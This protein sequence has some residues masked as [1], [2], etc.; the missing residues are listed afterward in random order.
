VRL[1]RLELYGFKSF[2]QKT[3]LELG[4]GITAIVGP[5]G[6]GKSNL[7][8]AIR[9]ALGEQSPRQLRGSKMEDVIFGG[10]SSRKALGLA[11]VALYFDNEDGSLPIDFNEVSV[12]RR[13]YRSGESE[14][15]L[16]NSPCRLRDI[17]DLFAGTGVGRETYATIEQG[18]ID[19]LCSGRSEDRRV[20][21][22]EASGILKYKHKKKEALSKLADT[23]QKIVRLNDLLREITG[24]LAPLEIARDKALCYQ[25]CSAELQELE[26]LLALD[27]MAHLQ[28]KYH[29]CLQQEESYQ[30]KMEQL[31][32]VRQTTEE[33]LEQSAA[34]L[35]A[36]QAKLSQVQEEYHG[37]LSQIELLQMEMKMAKERE[38][39]C[40][41]RQSR[42]RQREENFAQSVQQLEGEIREETQFLEQM[43]KEM[44]FLTGREKEQK[45]VLEEEQKALKK[46]EE[47]LDYLKGELIETLNLR[48]KKQYEVKNLQNN[49]QALEKKKARL[50]QEEE[51]FSRRKKELAQEQEQMLQEKEAKK[52]AVKTLEEEVPTLQEGHAADRKSLIAQTDLILQLEK[53]GQSCQSRLNLLL[54][55][56]RSLEGY[57]KGVKAVLQA[58]RKNSSLGQGISGTVAELIKVPEKYEKAIETALG[59]ALQNIVTKTEKKAQE[60][61]EYLK[62]AKSGRATFLPLNVIQGSRQKV[63]PMSGVL[64]LGVD[65]VEFA[66]QYQAVMEYLLGR[67]VIVEDLEKA[68]AVSQKQNYKLRIVTLEGDVITPGGAM[69][70]GS[71]GGKQ[72]GFLGRMREMEQLSQNL[73]EIKKKLVQE[74]DRKKE[75][76]KLL[77]KLEE[78]LQKKQ[79]EL[80][81]HKFALQSLEKDWLAKEKATTKLNQEEELMIWEQKQWEQEEELLKKQE[82]EGWDNCNSLE[83]NKE[84]LEEEIN[85]NQQDLLEKTNLLEKSKEELTQLKV[86][87]A[88]LTQ[89]KANGEL[90]QAKN[91]SRLQELLAEGQLNE[92]ETAKL[93]EQ[94]ENIRQERLQKKA[95]LENLGEEKEKT[96]QAVAQLKEEEEQGKNKV[97]EKEKS[98]KSLE[99]TWTNLEKEWIQLAGE[100]GRLEG[101]LAHQLIELKFTLEFPWETADFLLAAEK[102][103]QFQ[104]EALHWREQISQLGMVNLGALEEYARLK[105]RHDFLEEQAR[106]LQAAKKSL[107]KLLTEL[108]EIMEKRFLETFLCIQEEFKTLFQRLFNGGKAQLSLAEPENTLE[109]GIEIMVQPP[110]KKLQNLT[111]LSGGE[112]GLTA[113]AL[114]FALLKVNPS[115]F[116][117]LDEIDAAFDDANVKRVA[118]LLKE[119]AQEIQFLV[120]THRKGIMEEADALYGVT[121]EEAGVSHL[122]SVKLTERAS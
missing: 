104:Q 15:H 1:K 44:T 79:E 27:I 18:K 111:L 48:A 109:T 82:A 33:E 70:G 2:A 91:K 59:P 28:E 105:K 71:L 113:V 50:L 94:A 32:L 76:E 66:S 99:R 21:F 118:D 119:F 93:L 47:Y 73:E 9:W 46:R 34:F 45:K 40:L 49:R 54:E 103:A 31:Q 78:T 8:D 112:K 69:S 11:E 97:K 115:P 17:Y 75:Q 102:K 63:A 19:L 13:I 61:I 29:S 4:E 37:L 84:R 53:D 92:Q 55:M 5:N 122:V 98:K 14:Y 7:S 90:N 20:V 52:I 72:L 24:Q 57:A 77:A 108:D 81:Q 65:L 39:E 114:L 64:G 16:N 42:L 120:I 96:A 107:E 62:A 25:K 101:D 80:R 88:F 67:I 86:Q 3:K 85:F 106:D 68:L 12:S 116:C 117:L 121:M 89:K 95:K 10:S 26:R 87:L 74:Q 23:A 38:V 30:E 6:S 35:E 51:D 43:T 22:E 60:L 100:K 110:G 41:E 58:A 83:K 56:E 36:I